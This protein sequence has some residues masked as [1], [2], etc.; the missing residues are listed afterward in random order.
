MPSANQEDSIMTNF[1][2]IVANGH[3]SIRK[4]RLL[5]YTNLFLSKC[6]LSNLMLSVDKVFY[7]SETHYSS[8][9]IFCIRTSI[10]VENR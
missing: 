3:G 6:S 5:R 7:I 8:P 2:K 10:E 1:Y 9:N 4:W